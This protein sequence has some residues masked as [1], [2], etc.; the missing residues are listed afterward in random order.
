MKYRTAKIGDVCT[1]T[2]QQNPRNN[3]ESTFRYVDIS[4]IN[5]DRKEITDPPALLGADA[6]SRARKQIRVN[7]VLVSTVRPNL[8]AVAIVQ[9]ELDGEIASTG[10]CVLRANTEVVKPGYLFYKVRT[11]DFIQFLCE[12]T[13][14]A[15]YPAVTDG[16]VKQAQIP[17]P[18]LP[19]QERI[20]SILDAAE[21][22]CR[23]REQADRCTADLIP[24]LFNEMF[25][26]PATNPKGWPLCSLQEMSEKLSDGP[27]GSN[28]KSSHYVD[29][30]V[31]V[32]RLQNIGVGDFVDDDKAYISNDHF[33]NLIKHRCVSGDILIGT[34]GDPNLRACILPISLTEALNKADCIQFRPDGRKTTSEYVCWML[35]MPGALR[36]VSGHI[37]GQTRSRISLG[38]IRN[39]AFPLPPLSLQQDFAE[40]VADIRSM[41]ANQAKSRC[42]LD[43]LF[44]SLLHHAF[45]GDL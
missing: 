33:T 38:R 15:S 41:G 43:N 30:G 25:G 29:K 18:S 26:D 36:I 40:R 16:I 14:G 19:E 4:T 20:A 6:P 9:E 37:L 12:R 31:R 44:Q 39:I 8:N 2:L 3:P 28:L 21:E 42:R 45:R 1:E 35:N 7:D 11:P 24:A 22:L 23:L 17:L 34:L 10:F 27:F 32:V 5:R 13:I